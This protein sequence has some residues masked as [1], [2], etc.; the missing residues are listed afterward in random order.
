LSIWFTTFVFRARQEDAQEGPQKCR[1]A[2]LKDEQDAVAEGASAAALHVRNA[3]RSLKGVVLLASQ[4][5][6]L[7]TSGDAT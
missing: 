7:L 3:F 2:S 5:R 1:G 6:S 4:D